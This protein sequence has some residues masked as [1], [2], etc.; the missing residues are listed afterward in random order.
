MN[1]DQNYTTVIFSGVEDTA[2]FIEVV[3]KQSP[4]HIAKIHEQNNGLVA[5]LFEGF[6]SNDP[7]GYFKSFTEYFGFPNVIIRVAVG[8]IFA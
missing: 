3:K 4:F 2:K 8:N 7:N 1:N 6:Q 5:I